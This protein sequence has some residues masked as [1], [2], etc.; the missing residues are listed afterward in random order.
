MAMFILGTCFGLSIAFAISTILDWHDDIVEEREIKQE[1][2]Q[3]YESTP[4][5][6]ERVESNIIEHSKAA[7]NFFRAK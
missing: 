6:F 5:D 7:M 2:I 3:Q 4:V 1:Q